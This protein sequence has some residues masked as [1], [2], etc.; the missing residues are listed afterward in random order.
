MRWRRITE[1]DL[2]L[3]DEMGTEYPP[4]E[5]GRKLTDTV[6]RSIGLVFLLVFIGLLWEAFH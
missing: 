1:K 2:T 4:R 6:I 5:L 3:R